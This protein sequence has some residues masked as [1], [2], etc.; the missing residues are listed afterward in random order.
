V[1]SIFAAATVSDTY[2][3]PPNPSANAIPQAAAPLSFAT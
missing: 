1:G 2:I 3:K